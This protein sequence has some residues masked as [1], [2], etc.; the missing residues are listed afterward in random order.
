MLV[1][2]LS[3]YEGGSFYYRESDENVLREFISFLDCQETG[4]SIYIEVVDITREEFN[5]HARMDR[6]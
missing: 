4:N 5:N 3:E 2:K 1:Y 6:L